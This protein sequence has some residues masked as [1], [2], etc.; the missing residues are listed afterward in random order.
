MPIAVHPFTVS[1]ARRIRLVDRLVVHGDIIGFRELCERAIPPET[2]YLVLDLD[3][4]VHLG[5]NMG[6]LLGWELCALEGYGLDR[7]VEVE[8]R[9]P[10]SRL[11]LEWSRP[12]SVLRY[13]T[14]TARTWTRPG[15]IYFFCGKLPTHL[16]FARR[17]SFRIFGPEP[18]AA[19]QQVAQ[20]RLL[21]QM[22]AV[23]ISLLR[24]LAQRVWDRYAG[25]QVIE[26][27]DLAW[28]RSRCPKIRIIMTSASPQ[29]NL[30]VA[31]EALGLDDVIYS[32]IAEHGGYF[33]S[34]YQ[35]GRRSGAREPR[36]IAGP[37]QVRINSGQAK[38]TALLE[39]YPDLMDPAVVSVGMSDTGY[40]EDHCWAGLFT[41][42][43]DVNSSTPF[44]PIVPATSPIEEIHSAAVLSRSERMRRA[45]GDHGY[46]DPRRAP[47]A[48]LGH[49]FAPNALWGQLRLT[50]DAL[51]SLA[52]RYEEYTRSL[53]GARDLLRREREDV[54]SRITAVTAAFNAGSGTDRAALLAQ[55]RRLL[56]KQRSVRRR[57]ARLERPL[58]ELAFAMNGLLA[59]SRAQLTQGSG[60][61]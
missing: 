52:V 42:V 26:R 2:R 38:V 43:V 13:L 5:R 31:S 4:T 40:G 28:L 41:C 9:R 17:A 54:E 39:R 57:L 15:L 51:E 61:S 32:E 6:E 24:T 10:L 1:S 59:R 29:P 37:S 56:R 21:E 7:L 53:E 46:R 16:E 44:P 30:E 22:S 36:R 14:I 47:G 48:T 60:T 18:V 49:A 45:D 11:F 35:L 8:P 12:M 34:P 55:L 3:R 25:D 20:L 23:P 27:E 58:A 19:V 33:S 50:V